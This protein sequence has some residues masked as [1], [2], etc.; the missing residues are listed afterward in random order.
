MKTKIILLSLFCS[1]IANAQALYACVIFFV[2]Y[3]YLK[4]LF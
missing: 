3:H 4:V 1:K 2:Y